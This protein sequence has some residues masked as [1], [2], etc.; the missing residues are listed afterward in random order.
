MKPSSIQ[1]L[2]L[3]R[4]P[5]PCP[6]KWENLSGDTRKR[7]CDACEKQVLNFS[8]YPAEEILEEMDAAGSEPICAQFELDAQNQVVTKSSRSAGIWQRIAIS[9]LAPLSHLIFPGCG[10]E[11]GRYLPW[12]W[13]RSTEKP[14]N[15]TTGKLAP[16]TTG[17][18]EIEKV[19]TWSTVEE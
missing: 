17:K 6:I 11:D 19:D 10:A 18:V 7:F 15:S 12:N 1:E 16:R 9:L 2:T 5:D 3:I 4:I 14:S 8:E 13:V